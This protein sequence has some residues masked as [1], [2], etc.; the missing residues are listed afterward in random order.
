[1][2]QDE[3]INFWFESADRN[4]STAEDMFQGGHYDWSLFLWHLVLEK[5]LKGLIVKK[6][7]VPPPIHD[8]RKLA[9]QAG[10]SIEKEKERQL[11][12]ITS[13]NLEARYDDYKRS[14]YHKATKQYAS[15]WVKICEEIYLW[16]K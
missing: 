12:E 13:F 5:I 16:L 1:M 14:F 2:T 3:A 4:K 6:G 15:L 10:V 7:D 9:K 8:L 11:E